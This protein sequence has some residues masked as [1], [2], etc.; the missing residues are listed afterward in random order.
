MKTPL[1]EIYWNT[2]YLENKAPWDIG[3]I[4]TP[5]KDYIDQ[6]SDKSISILVPGA[7]NAYEAEY[8][9]KNE[10]DSVFICDLASEPLK[11]FQRRCPDFPS[12]QL[13]QQNF[14]D[15]KENSYDL[16]I[17]QTFFCA[18]DPELRQAYADKVHRLLKPG[19]KLVGL[20]FNDVFQA[21]GPPFGGTAKEYREYFKGKFLF[22]T[23]ETAS[24]SIKP[25]AGRELFINL[26]KAS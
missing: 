23:F 17:E 20:L 1:D 6:L 16:I 5:L 7:G 4:S 11:S 14:F 8:L 15:L 26:V 18:I 12:Q 2:R 25:R 9:F 19:G 22:K 13:L 3:N 24:N 10:F 21:E